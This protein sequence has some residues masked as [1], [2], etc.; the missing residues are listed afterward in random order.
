MKWQIKAL[1]LYKNNKYW[2]IE[3]LYKEVFEDTGANEL[4]IGPNE[5]KYWRLNG[6]L[7]RENGPAVEFSNGPIVKDAIGGK[8][9][10]INGEL[11][12]ENGPAIEWSNGEQEWYIDGKELTEEQFLDWSR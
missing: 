6:K 3:Q 4:I 1:Y 8:K 9:W 2:A 12:R 7:H 10:Y 11:H 5:S